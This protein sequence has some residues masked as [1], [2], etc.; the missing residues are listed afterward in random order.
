MS[1]AKPIRSLLADH[2]TVSSKEKINYLLGNMMFWLFILATL[3][4]LAQLIFFPKD[5]DVLELILILLWRYILEKVKY[6]TDIL[7]ISVFIIVLLMPVLLSVNQTI[8][9]G[10]FAIWIFYILIIEL[11]LNICPLFRKT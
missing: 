4:V 9:A 2:G 10:G 11:V 5:L 8:V 3:G 1:K 6:H 7:L